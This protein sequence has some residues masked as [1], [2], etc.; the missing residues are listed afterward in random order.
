M[1]I[2]HDFVRFLTYTSPI[3]LEKTVSITYPET[4]LS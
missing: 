2:G 4:L 3:N 1:T